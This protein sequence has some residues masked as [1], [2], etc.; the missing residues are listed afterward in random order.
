MDCPIGLVYNDATNHCDWRNNVNCS[1]VQ[2][3]PPPAP[4]VQP[5]PA[6]TP[7]SN[8]FYLDTNGV[9]VLCPDARVGDVG[10]VNGVTYTKRDRAGLLELVGTSEEADLAM[11]C[12][13]SVTDM[14]LMFVNANAFNVN[15]GS[16]DTSKVTTMFEM[17]MGANSFDQDISKWN[18]AAVTSIRICRPGMWLT[19]LE[20]DHMF[21]RASTFNQDISKWNTAQ[22]ASTREIFSL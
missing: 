15:I 7:P 6:P 8:R 3:P 21:N 19:S 2:P 9:T 13:S 5:P 18:A 4:T 1:T 20:M 10:V 22:A 12:T 11:S 17:F 16:W 14:S